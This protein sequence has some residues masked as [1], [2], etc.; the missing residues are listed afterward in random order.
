MQEA[1]LEMHDFLASGDLPRDRTCNIPVVGMHEV[2]ERPRQHFPGGQAQHL[3]ERSVDALEVAVRTSNAHHIQRELEETIDLILGL[4]AGRDVVHD[5]GETLES[6]SCVRANN[7]ASSG[8]SNDIFEEMMTRI[9]NTITA[10]TNRASALSS[11]LRLG[12]I[13][14]L[15]A[16]ALT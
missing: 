8:D 6:S 3:C 10:V 16:R 2:E 7:S 14:S 1:V 5:A 15:S 9:S 11:R 13:A 4:F 12:F